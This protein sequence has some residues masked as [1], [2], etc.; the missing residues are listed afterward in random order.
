MD[1]KA[2]FGNLQHG[3]P[4]TS[5]SKLSIL[6]AIGQAFRGQTVELTATPLPARW[7]DLINDIDLEEMLV[8]RRQSDG[9]HGSPRDLEIE[10][11][12]AL[13]QIRAS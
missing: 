3:D 4:F 1:C 8:E 9:G 6:N 12:R 11:A 13:K 5:M 10:I 7:R 2:P